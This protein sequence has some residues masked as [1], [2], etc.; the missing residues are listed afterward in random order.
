[1]SSNQ[2]KSRFVRVFTNGCFDIIHSGHVKLLEFARQ[3]GDELIVGLNSDYSVRRLKG[4][5]RPIMSCEDRVAVLEA[6]RWVDRVYVFDDPT[7]EGLICELRPQVLV[8]GP[9]AAKTE[10]PGADWVLANGGRVIVPDWPVEIS[11][12]MIARRC[13]AVCNA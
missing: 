8:K 6:I 7:P 13:K 5:G 12:T 9:E 10:I 2:A 1:M 11:T 3:Q 4:C